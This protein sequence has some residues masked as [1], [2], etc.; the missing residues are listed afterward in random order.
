MILDIS[1]ETTNELDVGFELGTLVDGGVYEHYEGPYEVTPLKGTQQVLGT[2]NK[3]M[4]DDVT[5][6]E[7]PYSEVSNPSGGKTANIAFIL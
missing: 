6:H 4:D 7:I 5:I 1:L 2:Q 3:L